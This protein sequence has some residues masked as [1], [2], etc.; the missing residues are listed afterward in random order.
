MTK[1]QTSLDL[2]RP[3]DD[4]A[5]DAISRATSIYGIQSVKLAP[6]LD[7]IVVEYD[8]SRLK[9]EHVPAALVRAG[10][11]VRVSS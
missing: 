11:P 7:R 1:V 10:V 2:V 5:L 3:L 8:A 4:P 9:P 6:A